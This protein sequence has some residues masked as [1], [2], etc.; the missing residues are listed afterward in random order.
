LR[1]VVAAASQAA[2]AMN[3][4]DL[5]QLIRDQAERLGTLLRLEQE[6]SEKS[7]AILE[8]IADGVMLADA[9]G[10]IRLFNTAAE[11]ILGLPRDKVMDQS[12]SELIG[13]FGGS[14]AAWV[15]AVE[16]WTIDQYTEQPGEYVDERLD[17][18]DRVVSVHLSP[19]Y[20]GEQLLGTVSV[21]RDI[22]R[23]VEVDRMKAGFVSNVSHEFRTPLTP[24]KGY[25][26]LL[27][28]GAAGEIS[29]AQQEILSTIKSNVDRLALLVEDVLD[30]SKID[31]GEE[32]LSL[33]S[34]EIADVLTEILE[35][36]ASQPDN[37]RKNITTSLDCEEDLPLIEADREKLKKVL[38]NIIDNAFNYTREG[39][40]IM[41]R[42]VALHERQNIRIAIQD[43]GIGIPEEFRESVWGRFQRHDK[44]ALS[45]D[46]AG[47]GL[48]MAIVKELVEMHHGQVWFDSEV[49]K[50]TTFYV[51]LPVEQPHFITGEWEAL[52][53]KA[54]E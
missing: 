19:V 49:E 31:A 41:V 25:T 53:V 1:L 32:K 11:R 45:M 51:L 15:R 22:T 54:E 13:L 33:A 27:M 47:T 6:E 2:S 37:L 12:L 30:I 3:N 5:Y 50:G 35:G 21:F 42:I 18:A 23:D 24:I 40:S 7:T 26:D 36:Q 9:E 46:V 17:L 14:A 39:G 4:A 34:F 43:T 38:G 29:E 16:E 44:T 10:N 28:M 8:G 48:G 52:Q 20:I